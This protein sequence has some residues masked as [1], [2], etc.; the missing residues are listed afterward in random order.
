M[1]MWCRPPASAAASDARPRLRVVIPPVPP[2]LH[3]VD[4]RIERERARRTQV[5]AAIE[6]A[7]GEHS[8]SK[9]AADFRT[10]EKPPASKRKARGGD[11]DEQDQALAFQE[12]EFR[13]SQITPPPSS[14]MLDYKNP[15]QPPRKAKKRRRVL[16]RPIN[17]V[18]GR[19]RFSALPLPRLS[20]SSE[21]SMSSGFSQYSQSSPPR[22]DTPP[23]S[24]VRMA[25]V[26]RSLADEFAAVQ[27][28]PPV[29]G[30][31]APPRIARAAMRRCTP[32]I[33]SRTRSAIQTPTM[34]MVLRSRQLNPSK[35]G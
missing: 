1:T 21:S 30:L 20:L 29:R 31:R 11:L 16:E 10:P 18:T 19:L 4:K 24:P 12:S 2:F 7:T 23:G 14:R 8:V 5:V 6:S 26:F 33:S 35:S 9:D 22:L 25:S 32:P 3:E 13:T 15:P 17:P 28:T 27:D 34:T